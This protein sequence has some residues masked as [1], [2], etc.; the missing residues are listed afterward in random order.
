MIMLMSFRDGTR[1]VYEDGQF[2]GYKVS[3]YNSH[4]R[5]GSPT[6]IETFEKLL[7]VGD[8]QSTMSVIKNIA[9]QISKYTVFDEVAIHT[10]NDTLAEQ[11]LFSSI[12]AM[13]IAEE[14]KEGSKLGKYVKLLGCYQVLIE[15]MEPYLAANWS[16]GRNWREIKRRIEQCGLLLEPAQLS[17]FDGIEMMEIDY[18]TQ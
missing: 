7:R 9:G 1:L 6:D 2:D 18:G 14:R 4:R 10:V 12:A 17:L 16:K 3:F 13:M 11:K 5:I 8:M 15:G